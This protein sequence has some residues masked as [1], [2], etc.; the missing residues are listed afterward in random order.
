MVPMPL[1]ISRLEDPNYMAVEVTL[2]AEK[3]RLL[4]MPTESDYAAITDALQKESAMV[5]ALDTALIDRIVYSV[6]VGGVS[7]RRGRLLDFI[8]SDR[9]GKRRIGVH[10]IVDV[11]GI[12]DVF[13]KHLMRLDGELELLLIVT[14]SSTNQCDQTLPKLKSPG[15]PL[16]MAGGYPDTSLTKAVAQ[17]L[18]DEL[19]SDL[20]V[21][22]IARF[23]QKPVGT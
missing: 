1:S 2:S 9:A 11:E 5:E 17:A 23:K 18:W 13:L 14:C 12:D 7:Y 10:A 21:G 3:T 16:S 15:P 20:K 6:Q 22:P 19:K 4:L 8:V